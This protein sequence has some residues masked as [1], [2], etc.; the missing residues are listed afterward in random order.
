MFNLNCVVHAIPPEKKVSETIYCNLA[1]LL[2][3]LMKQV[4]R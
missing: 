4:K 2:L 1:H 3:A